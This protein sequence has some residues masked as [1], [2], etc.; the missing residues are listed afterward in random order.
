MLGLGYAGDGFAAGILRPGLLHITQEFLAAD[1]HV[2]INTD[3]DFG[4]RL[5]AS[6]RRVIDL[7]F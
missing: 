7:L 3:N 4:H 6:W 1:D 2:V 5:L